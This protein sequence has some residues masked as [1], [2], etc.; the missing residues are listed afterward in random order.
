MSKR[1]ATTKAGRRPRSARSPVPEGARAAGG[2]PARKV[3]R[4]APTDSAAD[5]IASARELVWTGQHARAI[6]RCTQ[7]LADTRLSA[8]ERMALLDTRAEALV[9]QGDFD[10][11]AVD[12]AAMVDLANRQD[13]PALRAQALNRRVVVQMVR[14]D[15]KD[16]LRT[17]KAVVGLRHASRPLRAKSLCRLS[18]AQQRS[19]HS[20]AA[21][22][23][24]QRA[25]PLLQEAAD[26]SGQGRAHWLI[27]MACHRLGRAEESRRAAQ[28]ALELCQQAG[29]QYGIG[30]AFNL[31]N[32]TD[33]DLAEQI[34][35]ARAALQAYRAGGY[36]ERQ[37]VALGNL[38]ISYADLGLYRHVRRLRR[39]VSETNR[40]MGAKAAL[41]NAISAEAEI[42]LRL[43]DVAA[44]KSCLRQLAKLVPAVGDPNQDAVLA[45]T[46]AEVA[47]AE[48][49]FDAAIRHCKAAMQIARRAGFVREHIL[50]TQ[51]GQAYLGKG[52]PVAAL[53]CTT[54]A[55]ESHRSQSFAQP[56][57]FTSQEIWWR[58]AQALGANKQAA[59]AHAALERA[60]GFLLD[61]IAGVRDEGLRR[62]YLNKVK[63]NR[64]IVSAWLAE[65]TKRKLPKDR[66]FAHLA[67]E[68]NVREPF[69]RLADT[70]VR[71]NALHTVAAIQTF[72]VE[73]A[74]ELCGGERVLLVREDDGP[75]HV[76]ESVVPIGEVVPRLL[77]SI[78][79]YL[80]L[81]RTTRVTQ[82]LHTPKTG[83]AQKQ[84]SRIIAPLV[85][86][87]KVLGY[88]YADMDGIYG[89]F[90]DSDRDILGMLANQA[91]VALDNAQWA[92]GLERKVDERTAEL[93]RR[94]GELTIINS[95][96][97]GIAGSLDFQGIVDLVGDK[98]REVLRSDNVG[99][100]WI[101]HEKRS[102]RELYRVEH[103]KRL[104]LP[105]EVIDADDRWER[106]LARRGPIARNTVAEQIA[107][108]SFALPGTDQALSTA[109][110]PIVVGD[111]RVG[112]IS[113][114]NHER[115][116]AFGESELRLLTTIASSMGVALQS[117]LLFGET[118]RL[119]KETEQRNAELAIINSVQAALAAELDIQGIY[120]AVGD[121]I[122]EIFRNRDVGIRVYDPKTNLIHFP[123]AYEHGRKMEVAS[124]PFRDKSIFA[125]VI[126]S[127]ETLVVNE[128]MAAT[129]ARL[130]SFVLPGT[131]LEK[132]GIYVPLVTG[133]QARGLIELL[134]FDHEHAFSDS[135][136]RLLQTLANSMSVALENARLF[137]ETQRLLKETEQRAAELAV[138]NSI[139]QGMAGSLDFQGIVDLVGDTL[140]DVLHSQDLSIWWYDVDAK[141]AQGLYMIEHG[142]RLGV[143]QPS[144]M[145]P[146]GPAERMIATHKPVVMNRA[147]DVGDVLPGTD[148]AKSSVM[149]PIIVND[150]V[151]G[152]VTLEN[153]ER[154]DAFGESEIRLLETIAASMGV[155][156]QSARLFNETQRLLQETN[157]RA[158]ELA[159][160]NS[161][162]Q[163][164]ANKLEAQAIFE[165][166][167]DKLR[168]L[169][170][171]QAI[172]IVGF[173]E[174]RDNRH[175]HYLLER[176]QRFE[177][178]D[179]P[180][181]PLGWH[182]IRT[183]TPLLVNDNVVARLKAVGV[184]S[185]TLPG[186][187][188]A[189]CLVRVPILANERVIGVIGLDNMDRENAFDEADVRLLTTLAGSMSVAL[190]SARLFEQTKLLL[191]QAELRAGELATVNSI[192]QALAT[193]VDLREL[194]HM[195]G[196]RMR[197]T[198]HA[199]I[200]YVALVDSAA[201]TINFPYVYG[202]DLEPL[203]LGTGLTGR[204]IETGQALLIN[205]GMD[206]TDE[207]IGAAPVGADAK[208]YLGVPI[209]L[210]ERAIGVISVQSTQQEGRFAATDQ[211]LLTTI[212]TGVGVAIRNAQLF[213][214][215]K[216]ARAAAEGA[217]EAKSSFLATMSHEIRTPMNA[218]IGMS[219]LLLDTPLSDE[220]RDFAT[221]IRDS[222]DTL[223]TIINDILDF[224]K[225][226]AGRM[227]IEAQ[228]FDLR[229]CVESALDLVAARA[230]EKRLDIA[231]L[232]EGEVPTAVN[233]DVTR[234]RQILLNLLSNAVKFTESG[235]VVV[236]V[237]AEAVAP[238]QVELAFAVHDTGIGLSKEGM[239]RLF[240]SFSQADSSTT[241]KYGGTGLGLAISRRL[242]ELMGGRMW[243]H[244]DGRGKGSTFQV[245][246][247]VPLAEAKTASRRD[248]VGP[249]PGISGKRVLIVDDN[250]TNRKVLVLQTTKWGM[251]PRD[252]EYPD[253]ALRWL[254][255]G[256]SFDVGIL[257]M[258][259]PQLNGVMLAQ[260]I[261]N[262][263]PTLPL[264][265]WSSLGRREAGDAQDLFAAYLSKPVRQ[266]QLFD[267]LANLFSTDAA[268][269]ATTPVK[270][271]IDSSMAS[272]HPLRILLAEDN[273]VNQKLA[274]RLLQQMGYRADL[275]SNGVEAVESVARQTYDVV[276]MDV[277]MPEM[278]GLEATRRITAQWSAGE[279]PRI[280]AMTAN[281]M[282]G[283]REMCLAAGM[284]DYV[285]KPIRVDQLVEALN[286]VGARNGR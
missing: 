283:D 212:A 20:E 16:A 253:E 45:G 169:F 278:D 6:E 66:L 21:L 165:L 84:R 122:R 65:G 239:S 99:I 51:M 152:D 94:A 89:R 164:L 202:D 210:G 59:A 113:M 129:V 211:S 96:Q 177:M 168:E 198:F 75:R 43:G 224:S 15:M 262:L 37:A 81:T 260:R 176:G 142:R 243:A 265:L 280:V 173:D 257:D 217:N 48:S 192:G 181:A 109:T 100:A 191:G 118:Q 79:G 88:L 237:S 92:Q 27:A 110:V 102:I 252:T 38:A 87:N 186:T 44:A 24:A 220:Q 112:T 159:I 270:A 200:V 219:G 120:D 284:D 31:L 56:D 105:D 247:R 101:D 206:R 114:E 125:H 225:I 134:D 151:L 104:Q 136:V 111:R 158:A 157:D 148:R 41:A 46:R 154:E 23:T 267:T 248:F 36:A 259:M 180:I 268:P 256:N 277:Q 144:P 227:D 62:N 281:A 132:S 238:R 162:Q 272:R 242:A 42:E 63:V 203:P 285:T 145:R 34:R 98:L 117:A 271:R 25:V 179:A 201:G 121:K 208:S 32:F 170:D 223:L 8:D 14:G 279:R 29:D 1:A 18:E 115:E 166:V 70:G 184:V 236:T 216:E 141:L 78:G 213:Q 226:E 53:R 40:R 274:L 150:R 108:G 91:A 183:A 61:G 5:V 273:V 11:A 258:H 13:R 10:L 153:H 146:G 55:T 74:T 221:T 240:Q 204:I 33:V 246:V 185:K 286:N 131:A 275:A 90:D 249:Q 71:L 230:A 199:D 276:L 106:I 97:Q 187:Q 193:H 67:I 19:G 93:E 69:Q 140:R 86:Q 214:D 190:E 155:A 82:L 68:S 147:D 194:I 282:Q 80:D 163:G 52:E 138:I 269:K 30:N 182:M 171:S 50:L 264:V 49:D 250:A 251:V 26:V 254:G 209:V 205:E 116:Y 76:A 263:N 35:H 197:E 196:E 174:E 135:D 72:L 234:L 85:I 222:G 232:F 95:I 207:T 245:T 57:G 127:R 4:R 2:T 139:Q 123:Y 124:I 189:R 178:P 103:G 261:R 60:Y 244:S 218:V 156:L 77:R 9:A 231:Y 3:D 233:G 228:P 235:E 119:L 195:V 161:V 188:P 7:R 143:L 64:E 215:A 17:A 133:D 172:S 107:A 126:G 28:T 47:L 241:R 54:Q 160:I 149:M 39:E 130:G 175:Y 266:S 73:E 58:H 83:S 167:G 229:E 255:D 137:D 128:G 22:A 12:A